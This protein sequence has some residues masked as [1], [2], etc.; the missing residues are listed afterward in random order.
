MGKDEKSGSV[1]SL[2]RV[3]QLLDCDWQ[4]APSCKKIQVDIKYDFQ[5]SNSYSLTS[6][7]VASAER[8]YYSTPKLD[9]FFSDGMSIGRDENKF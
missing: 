5:R 7:I 6:C 8:L 1:E 3:M 2:P 4:I 9:L